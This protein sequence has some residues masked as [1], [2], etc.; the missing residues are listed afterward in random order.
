VSFV[1]G[2]GGLAAFTVDSLR[3]QPPTLPAAAR[4]VSSATAG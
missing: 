2:V 3:P 4:P 1:V